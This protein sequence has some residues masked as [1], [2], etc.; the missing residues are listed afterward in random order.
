[1][2]ADKMCIEANTVCANNDGGYECVCADGFIADTDGACA[3]VD[4]CAGMVDPCADAANTTCANNEGG[5]EC[6]CNAGYAADADGACTDVD[7]CGAEVAPCDASAVCVNSEGSFECTCEAAGYAP[8]EDGVCADVDECG[9]ELN[10]CGTGSECTNTD[11]AFTCVCGEGFTATEAGNACDNIDECAAPKYLL[12]QEDTCDDETCQ[13]AVGALDDWCLTDWDES[14]AEC[15]AGGETLFGDDCSGLGTACSGGLSDCDD[16]S[17]CTDTEGSFTCACNEGFEGDGK[18]CD[19]IDECG[20]DTDPCADLA[21]STCT[22]NDGGYECVCSEGYVADA[23]DGACTDTDECADEGNKA[24]GDGVCANTEGSFTCDCSNTG[25]TGDACKTDIDECD[26]EVSPCDASAICNNTVGKFECVCETNGY[27]LGDDGVCTD[28]NECAA[29]VSPCDP[30]ANCA[31]TDG[32]YTCAC[33]AGYSGDGAACSPTGPCEQDD[34]LCQNGGKCFSTTASDY[35]C[36]CSF[37]FSGADCQY[38][39]NIC[40]DELC[41]N[42]TCNNVVE[43]TTDCLSAKSCTNETCKAAVC[44]DDS[45]CCGTNW[46]SYCND[47][48]NGASS[49]EDCSAAKAVCAAENLAVESNITESACECGDGFTGNNCEFTDSIC[50]PNPCMY[51]GSCTVVKPTEMGAEATVSCECIEG[52]S[53]DDCS[54]IDASNDT[55][56]CAAQDCQNGGECV[57]E[58]VEQTDCF[59]EDSCENTVCYDAVCAAD[60][61]CCDGFWDE[62]CQSCAEKGESSFGD[63]SAA[64]VTCA[65]EELAI[66][67]VVADVTCTCVDGTSGDTCDCNDTCSAAENCNADLGICISKCGE[68]VTGTMCGLDADKSTQC[69]ADGAALCGTVTAEDGTESAF[70]GLKCD[71]ANQFDCDE[72]G[73]VY[74]TA[75]A[76][77]KECKIITDEW[78]SSFSCVAPAL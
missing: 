67:E 48:A 34:T 52:F 23:D 1:E 8:G 21:N 14:C 37:G 51:G 75:C 62:F 25:F 69:A 63:C 43:E 53:G 2:G 6:A 20:A 54:T 42:G 59:N 40:Y 15:A 28:A 24:C 68:C 35:V 11:G 32:S 22:N 29:E 10:P 56:I 41:Q 66:V 46:P 17:T 19:D 65:A 57:I 60:D 33:M 71:G 55:A 38:D 36:D 76:D 77:G 49:F 18:V 74:A 61:V 16:G 30:M 27:I 12:C 26:T 64:V 70:V 47:C 78:G 44:A 72:N 9:A 3:D 4:E 58:K 39:D 31:N 73:M 50:D 7:E 13:A 45:Y 5:Y